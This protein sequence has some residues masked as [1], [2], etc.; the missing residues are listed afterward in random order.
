VL[1]VNGHP[2]SLAKRAFIPIEPEP[3]HAIDDDLDGFVGGS[4]LVCV[5]DPED[6][7]S[8]MV[9]GEQPIEESR[10]YASDMQ[11][12]GGTRGKTDSNIIQTT[13]GAAD[14]FAIVYIAAL[15][16]Q[17]IGL[18]KRKFMVARSLL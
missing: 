10:P 18:I 12:S 2:L 16:Y 6:E 9:P 11:G 8:S 3:F 5:L 17:N 13:H 14:S 7:L 4:G 1:T 15:L